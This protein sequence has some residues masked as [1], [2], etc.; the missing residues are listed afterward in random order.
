MGQAV[1]KLVS[2]LSKTHTVKINVQ[3]Y[4]DKQH[5]ISVEAK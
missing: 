3:I 1:V 5:P 2:K 4:S